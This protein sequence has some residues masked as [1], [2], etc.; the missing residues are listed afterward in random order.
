MAPSPQNSAPT[1]SSTGNLVLVRAAAIAKQLALSAALMAS[2]VLYID[3]KN[4]GDPAFCGVASGCFAVRISPYSHIVGVPLPTLALPAFAILFMASLL[5]KTRDHHR[6][7]AALATLGSLAAIAL[8]VI[9]GA[10]I[11]AFCKWCVIVDSSAVLAGAAAITIA[12][13]AGS[14][15][16]VHNASFGKTPAAAWAIA[17][18]LAVLVPFV[19]ARYPEVPPA[20]P[21]IQAEQEAGKV[22]IVAFT[23]FECPYCRKLH[24]MIDKALHDH[25]D[26]VR[27]VRKMKPLG[28]HPG[29]MPAAKAF[30]CT[31]EDKR[32][33]MADYLYQAE[34]GVLGDKQLA[35]T[36]EKMGFGDRESFAQCMASDQTAKTIARDSEQFT[37]LGG[38]GLPYTWIG[39]RVVLGANGPRLEEAVENEMAGPRPVLP[40]SAMFAVLGAVFV[41]ASI[42]AGRARV[43]MNSGTD[44]PTD[45]GTSSDRD[46]TVQS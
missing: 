20:P 43:P 18:A 1:P 8:I 11:G 19:W 15:S 17:G 40:V 10:L 35:A 31:P 4:A 33:A 14:E 41:V 13:G 44:A 23:D 16:S 6:I 46:G 7:V 9:Q 21:E 28:G 42:I 5:S 32:S 34:T 24:P 37:K 27:L 30:L 36:A 3:Y 29:A 22:T 2:A 38:K 25:P 26:K 39:P 12:L 45:R